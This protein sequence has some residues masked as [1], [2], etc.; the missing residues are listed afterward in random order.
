MGAGQTK[1]PA[2]KPQRERIDMII[3]KSCN[4]IVPHLRISKEF[5]YGSCIK[6]LLLQPAAFD[7]SWQKIQQVAR[8][9]LHMLS[10]AASA[11]DQ[12]NLQRLNN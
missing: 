4:N 6:K 3:C 12:A 7:Y 2:C 1:A 9:N 11:G 8:F 5:H 10:I